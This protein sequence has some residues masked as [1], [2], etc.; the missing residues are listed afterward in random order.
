MKFD[1]IKIVLI[2]E[3]N[4]YRI[5]MQ[6]NFTIKS[7]ERLTSESTKWKTYIPSLHWYGSDNHYHFVKLLGN[8]KDRKGA[9]KRDFG[10]SY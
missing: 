7:K 4:F 1:K 3:I 5:Y 10:I 9:I 8:G 6:F 2:L